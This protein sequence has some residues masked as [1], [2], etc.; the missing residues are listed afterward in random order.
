MLESIFF[1]IGAVT[2]IWDLC[3]SIGKF[4]TKEILFGKFGLKCNIAKTNI[5]VFIYLSIY[6]Y[7]HVYM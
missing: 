2:E 1:S 4:R 5:G 6:I 3:V 7:T